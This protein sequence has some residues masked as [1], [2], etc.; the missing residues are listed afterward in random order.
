MTDNLFSS[1]RLTDFPHDVS[2]IMLKA[3]T[4]LCEDPSPDVKAFA[5][6]LLTPPPSM[7]YPHRRETSEIAKSTANFSR[8]PP[9]APT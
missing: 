9:L 4:S 2:S 3:A 8:P 5:Q 6:T 7:T 1:G